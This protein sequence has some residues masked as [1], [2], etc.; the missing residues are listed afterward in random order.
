MGAF[1]PRSRSDFWRYL[2]QRLRWVWPCGLPLRP[3]FGNFVFD[4]FD[5]LF[6]LCEQASLVFVLARGCVLFAQIFFGMG[7]VCRG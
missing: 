4:V 2:G 7:F 6:K 5:L 3:L 1:C